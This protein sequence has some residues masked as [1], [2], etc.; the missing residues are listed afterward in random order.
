MQEYQEVYE[1]YFKS[2]NKCFLIFKL[3]TQDGSSIEF[4][5]RLAMEKEK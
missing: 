4:G 3:E 5:K 2:M 1:L